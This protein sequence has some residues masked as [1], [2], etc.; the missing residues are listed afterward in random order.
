MIGYELSGELGACVIAI[1]NGH[2]APE[3]WIFADGID[4]MI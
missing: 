1:H 2:C 3:L 4:D